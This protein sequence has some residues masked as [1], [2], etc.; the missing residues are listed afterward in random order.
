VAGDPMAD[1]LLNHAFEESLDQSD[2]L[3]SSRLAFEISVRY[4]RVEQYRFAT[5]YS[6]FALEAWRAFFENRPSGDLRAV[7]LT[8][9]RML[10]AST[11]QHFNHGHFLIAA[12][13][14]QRARRL[15]PLLPGVS[16]IAST[17]WNTAIMEHARGDFPK[18]LEHVLRAWS[19]Y[20]RHSDLTSMARLS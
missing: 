10:N 7:R 18:A 15:A 19:I 17:E 9:L 4:H 14:I 5:T 1:A 6:D 11:T 20:R 13:R 12:E 3:T 16:L 8:E 2:L